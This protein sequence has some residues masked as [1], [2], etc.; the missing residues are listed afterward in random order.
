MS[1][2]D[3]GKPPTDKEPGGS[4]P[5]SNMKI[6]WV[7]LI[8]ILFVVI[9]SSLTLC[10]QSGG[11]FAITQSALS[12][13]GGV[14]SAGNF[15][16]TGTNGQPFAGTAMANG[17]FGVSGGFWN[18]PQDVLG[19]Q[20]IVTTS[21]ATSVTIMSATLNGSAN[22]NSQATTGWF[23][24]SNSDPGV[25][26]DM[27]GTRVPI[28]GG[29]ALGSGSMP[30]PYSEGITGLM[31]GA[32]YYFCAIASNASGTSFGSVLSFV[33]APSNTAPDVTTSAATSVTIMSA[34]LNG[35]ANPNGDATT[36][37]FRYSQM[38]PGT[39]N[40]TFGTRAPVMGGTALGSGA[41]P[42]PYSQGITGLNAGSTYY[43]C[44]IASNASGTSFG[45]VLS[46]SAVPS[47]PTV[48]T[49]AAT[50]VT[51]MSATLNGA[52]NPNGDATTGWFRYSQMDPGTCND[53]FGTRAPVMGGT[54]VG[55]GSMPV[56]YSQPI[57]GLNPGSTYYFCAIASN[58]AG[59]SFGSVL[60][61]VAAP[62]GSTP[63][64][65]TSAATAVTF[66]SATLNGS[67]N[68]NGDT[69]TGWFRYSN[70][71][72]GTCNDMFGTRAPIMG[73][74]AL[75]NGPMPVPY[76]EG[77]TGLMPGGTYYYC[78]IASNSSGTSFGSVLS[79]V[80]AP[81]APSVTTTTATSV[82]PMSAT[83]NGSANPNSDATTGWFRYSSSDPGTCNDMFG[84]RAPVM[85]GTALGMGST[86][87]SYSEA[88]AGLNPGTTYY[89]C[90]IAS[91][92]FGTSF[93][94][95]LAFSGSPSA[96]SGT[97]T[98]G[99]AIGSPMPP[100]FVKNVSLASTS[101]MPPVG[102][103]ITGTPGTY[104]LTGFGMG[105][106]TIKPTKP[107][108]AT[109]A[110][111]SNDAA[112]IAQGV[113][114]SLPFVSQNQRFAAD[115]TGNGAISSQ[116]AAK[117]AQF[118]AGLPFS[119]PNLTGQWKFFVTGAPSP[120][121][122]PPQTYNDSRS[123]PMG[124]T[125]SLT[126]EDFVGILVGEVS[127]N[128]NP[129]THPRPVD[130]GPWTV[131]SED[132]GETRPITITTQNVSAAD[133]EI[134]VP[135]NVLGVADK[136]IISYE[137]DLRYDPSV[138]QPLENPV[139][140]IGTVSRGLSI[141]V[142]AKERGLLRV[143]AYGAM[144][145]GGD[146]VLLNLRFSA[147]GAFGSVSPLIWERIMLNEGLHLDAISGQ[148]KLSASNHN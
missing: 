117:I 23:R 129:A 147:V 112:R 18:L 14:I 61:F 145:I 82:T 72:P 66:T 136:G 130:S 11:S 123:Y 85:G 69:A 124:V 25:C 24:Y 8:V 92:S 122:T 119:A 55:S 9:I 106:Y 100:R 143:V 126:G 1:L 49:T 43:F 50:S 110:I 134:V 144:P 114:G 34:T 77:I 142:N 93:G 71:D 139:D 89:F 116:D 36:G 29:T 79:F 98:Y 140:V 102:P 39:C 101:G 125:G 113:A 5:R 47:A 16:V 127:G 51:I 52:A 44:A 46:F 65:T 15:G 107:G 3:C 42:V 131:N 67:A 37:W 80:A 12:N 90:A 83:L 84:T 60:S 2:T 70:S 33:A 96:V 45:S 138:I 53:M 17:N 58:T 75:G 105:P 56:S 10:A 88:I 35:S 48:T 30:V 31:P 64:V 13:G 87:V 118:V 41:M 27:F 86:P 68:P 73:G 28:M 62:S 132:G 20:P 135:V 40:D 95:V 121:P 108:G 99:N 22:P 104:T 133:K 57:T 128:W 63:S 109:T 141:V 111:T 54:A 4:L 19:S 7:Y 137:F 21:G 78:A 120:L 6:N 91:N 148:V 146:G 94:S 97:V 38:N 115:V 103:V 81:S 76:S 74:T 32:T 26:N 59:P